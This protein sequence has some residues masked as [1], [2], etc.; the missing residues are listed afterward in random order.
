M[1]SILKKTLKVLANFAFFQRF[2]LKDSMDFGK[3]K[4]HALILFSLV[5]EEGDVAGVAW[6]RTPPTQGEPRSPTHK[7][8]MA[9]KNYDFFI[10]LPKALR[11]ER[12]ERVTYGRP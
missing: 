4:D 5:W 1:E 2:R 11:L 3:V 8:S 10:K 9:R 7:F 12:T 6:V